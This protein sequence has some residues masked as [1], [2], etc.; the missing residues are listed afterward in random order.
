[1][2]V[3]TW[4]QYPAHTGT[5]RYNVWTKFTDTGKINEGDGFRVHLGDTIYDAF[6]FGT[7]DIIRVASIVLTLLLYTV[8]D[9][10]QQQPIVDD[11]KSAMAKTIFESDYYESLG[12]FEPWSIL[13][14]DESAHEVNEDHV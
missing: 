4:L 10:Q 13:I 11:F 8:L 6:V 9:F 7:M 12:L 2:I 14:E 3:A 5:G 1:L